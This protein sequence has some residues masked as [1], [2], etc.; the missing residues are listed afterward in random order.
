[1]TGREVAVMDRETGEVISREFV[2]PTPAERITHAGAVAQAVKRT[3]IDQGL[4][5]KISG[6]DYILAEGW[7]AI[8]GAL[9]GSCEVESVEPLDQGRGWLA[10]AVVRDTDGGVL[11][12]GFAICTREESRWKKADEYAVMSMAQTRAIGKAARSALGYIAKAAGFEATPAEEMPDAG[13]LSL[14]PWAER[15]ND[16]GKSAANSAWAALMGRLGAEAEDS[17]AAWAKIGQAFG[18]TM[19]AGFV[20]AIVAIADIPE[21]VAPTGAMDFPGDGA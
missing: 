3:I 17:G 15:A 20:A 18:G 1:M 11:G 12:R 19:P 2:P 7:Q 6:N 14:P 8:A 16:A 13:T 5:K 4:T 21:Q 9:G 10:K